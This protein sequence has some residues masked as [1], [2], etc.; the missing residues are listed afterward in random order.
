MKISIDA[1]KCIAS[2]LCA[3]AT[4]SV[5]VQDEDGIAHVA[6]EEPPPSLENEVREAEMAC[7]ALAISVEE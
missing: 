5:F 2:G 3:A 6:M 7:P 4:P 1:D